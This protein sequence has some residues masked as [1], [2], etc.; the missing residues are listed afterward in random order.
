MV[1]GRDGRLVL[2]NTTWRRGQETYKVFL[3]RCG[4]RQGDPLGP[5][6]FALGMMAA[7]GKVQAA[8]PGF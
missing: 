4:S 6:L 2:P 3:S 1:Y 8:H 7:N 5:I